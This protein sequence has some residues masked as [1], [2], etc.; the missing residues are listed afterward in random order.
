MSD[1]PDKHDELVAEIVALRALVSR[2]K[3][4]LREI[5]RVAANSNLDNDGLKY[6]IH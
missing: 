3:T 2:L 1:E 6:V 4:D 5:I